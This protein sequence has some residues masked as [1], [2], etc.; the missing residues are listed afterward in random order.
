M[1]LGNIKHHNPSSLPV[2]SLFISKILFTVYNKE[3]VPHP[4]RIMMPKN[5]VPVGHAEEDVNFINLLHTTVEATSDDD[6]WAELSNIGNLL[7]KKH[8]N[9]D[10][11]TYG[12]SKI[13]DLVSA[14]PQFDVIRYPPQKGK[15]KGIY[16]RDKRRKSK[17]SS[18]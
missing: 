10:S 18:G 11:R 5:H 14:L 3:L 13:S 6:G 17:N 9:F 15:P 4:N 16:V 12:Y 8:P 7:T 1:V 2:T